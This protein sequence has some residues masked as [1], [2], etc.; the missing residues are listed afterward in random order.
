MADWDFKAWLE[1]ASA[2]AGLKPE[3]RKLMEQAFTSDP[4]AQKFAGESF[5]RQSDYSR[6]QNEL[7]IEKLKEHASKLLAKWECPWLFVLTPKGF[8]CGMSD[9]ILKENSINELSENWVTKGRQVEYLKLLK[10]FEK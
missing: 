8:Y 7:N 3:T 6:R 1:D 9:W 5:L 4:A 2:N 10:E